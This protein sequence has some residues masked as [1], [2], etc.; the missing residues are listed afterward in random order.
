M[1]RVAERTCGIASLDEEQRDKEGWSCLGRN[2]RAIPCPKQ[3][4]SS[5]DVGHAVAGYVRIAADQFETFMAGL[6]D[7]SRSNGSR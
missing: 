2:S 7:Q 4:E 5:D 1:C 6:G 3:P